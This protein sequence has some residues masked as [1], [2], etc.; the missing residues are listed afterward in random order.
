MTLENGGVPDMVGTVL[1][2]T[3][4][5]QTGQ[6]AIVKVNGLEITRNSNTISDAIEGITLNLEGASEGELVTLT[7]TRDKTAISDAI[8]DFVKALNSGRQ[9]IIDQ[10]KYN[11]Q[12]KTGG[13]LIGDTTARLIQNRLLEITQA[14]VPA[15]QTARLSELNDGAGVASGS[16]QI[17]DKNGGSATIDL[18]NTYTVQ[19]VLDAINAE[20]AIEITASVNA[21]GTAIVLTDTSAGSGSITVAEAGSTTAA[22]LGILGTSSGDTLEGSAVGDGTQIALSTIGIKTNSNG[23]LQIDQDKFDE[24]LEDNFD[25]VVSL[26]TTSGIG[27]GQRAEEVADLLT[28]PIDGTIKARQDT[29]NARINSMQSQIDRMELLLT[30]REES[31]V[32][33]FSAMERIVSQYQSVGDFLTNQLASYSK[34]WGG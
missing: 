10:T 15:M 13:P 9:F 14:S 18:T 33:Q 3:Q 27:L 21:D 30:K 2:L 8:D 11:A 1:G 12:T 19:D 26:F 24:A 32:R 5:N 22:D 29:I 16:I 20:D 23:T 31:L 25:A 4:V 28:D 17:T 6:S 34:G 7:V